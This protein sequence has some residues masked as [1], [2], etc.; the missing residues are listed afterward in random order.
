MTIVLETTR[1]V[2][3]QFTAGD[4][5]LIWLLNQD[6]EVT[7]F[8]HDPVRDPEHA[9]EVLL[10]HILPQYALYNFG[11]WAVHLKGNL[12]FIGWCGLKFRPERME[13]DLGYRLMKSYWG[14]G[15]ATEAAAGCLR[16]GFEKL[17]IQEIIGRAEPGNMASVRVLEKCGMEYIGNEMVDGFNVRTYLAR[18]PFIT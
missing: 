1:L 7:Q 5:E 6:P 17:H 13:T 9:G 12:D 8:T 11:R 18:N 15:Y 16:F 2:I 4:A 3:R 10:Q 14:K